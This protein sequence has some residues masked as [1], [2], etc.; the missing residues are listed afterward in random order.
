MC[1]GDEFCLGE[2]ESFN[3]YNVVVEDP[4]PKNDVHDKS[5]EIV[6]LGTGKCFP[7]FRLIQPVRLYS[8][9]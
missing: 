2:G 8:I 9:I 4:A 7:F 6:M 1:I 5:N 3:I